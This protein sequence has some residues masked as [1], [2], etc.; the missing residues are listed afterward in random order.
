[1]SCF[2]FLHYTDTWARPSDGTLLDL[3]YCVGLKVTRVGELL[4]E[5][6]CSELSVQII[7]RYSI[8][9]EASY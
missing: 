7:C 5:V 9:Q 2:Q 3:S 1:M 6:V 4:E 8:V